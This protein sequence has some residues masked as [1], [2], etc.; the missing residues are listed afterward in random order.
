MATMATALVRSQEL[1]RIATVANA[2]FQAE[3]LNAARRRKKCIPRH[4]CKNSFSLLEN[5]RKGN[6]TAVF[7]T[8]GLFFGGAVR[9]LHIKLCI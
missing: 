4:K 3:D 6:R 7:T 1:W 2:V 8:D 5:D 9:G